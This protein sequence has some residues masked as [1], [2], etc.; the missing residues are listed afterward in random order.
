MDF[1]EIEL[2]ELMNKNLI[3]DV[4]NIKCLYLDSSNIS[5][6]S[7]RSSFLHNI[8]FLSLQYNSFKNLH[9]IKLFPN[10][11]YLDIRYNQVNIYL[12]LD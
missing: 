9:F 7:I 5:H 4:N 2:N 12:K 1:T 10:L 8:Q 11:V 6:F 3:K